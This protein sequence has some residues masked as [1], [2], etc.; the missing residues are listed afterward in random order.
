MASHP[1][2]RPPAQPFE[3]YAERS[4]ASW[5]QVSGWVQL[6]GQRRTVSC[7]VPCDRCAPRLAVLLPALS[8]TLTEIGYPWEA[9][10]VDCDD[11]PLTQR[12]LAPWIEL[13]GFRVCRLPSGTS[14]AVAV[15]VGLREARGDLV[16]IADPSVVDVTKLIAY[17]IARWESGDRH[18]LLGF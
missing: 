6:S 2:A 16:M 15:A 5:A 17:A 10:A 13:P 12:I 3:P 8:D 7:I 11:T 4:G 9:I 18:R 14:R 1:F